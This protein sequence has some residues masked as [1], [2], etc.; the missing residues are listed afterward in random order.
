MAFSAMFRRVITKTQSQHSLRLL[1]SRLFIRDTNISTTNKIVENGASVN[2]YRCYSAQTSSVGGVGVGLPSYMRGA[3][4]WEPN[5]PLTIEDFRMPR[6]KSGE[7]LIKT[8]GIFLFLLKFP[9]LVFLSWILHLVHYST[10]SFFAADKM[11][12][13]KVCLSLN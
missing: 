10:A 4:F 11:H 9:F 5:K 8:K 12:A 7:I 13:K 1:T 6:P 3:V 2:S